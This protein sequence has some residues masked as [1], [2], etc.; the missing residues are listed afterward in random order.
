MTPAPAT[1]TAKRWKRPLFSFL[2][3]HWV[4]V[5]L[6]AVSMGYAG[7]VTLLHED[8]LSPVDEW[9]YVDYLYKLPAQG[10]VHE[11]EIV[12][13]ETLS[14]LACEGTSPFGT[15]GPPCAE[16]FGDTSKFPNEGV[17][18]AAAYT[19]LYFAS[20]RI[21]GD[22]IH[23]VTGIQQ[24]ESWRLTGVLWLAMSMVAF[25]ALARQWRVSNHAILSLGLAFIA[26]PLAW[27]TYT[28]VSTDAPSFFFGAAMLYLSEQYLRGKRSGWWLPIVS[29]LAVAVKLTNLLA[30]GLMAL[31][32]LV[33]WL[34]EIRQTSRIGLRSVQPGFTNRYSL[35]MLGFPV[36]AVVLSSTVQL[37][38][39]RLV[40]LMAVSDHRV[41]QGISGQLTG[42]ELLMQFTNFLPGAIVYSPISSFLPGF[43]FT[44]LTWICVASVL[45]AFFAMRARDD[46]SSIVI[47][48]TFAAA[49]FAPMLAIAL[50]T[51]TG[52]YFQLPSRY[53]APILAGFLLL[54][55]LLLRNK[56]ASWLVGLFATA[57]LVVGVWLSAYLATLT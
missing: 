15:I 14:L 38:W 52:S 44:P 1:P 48:V 42:S 45:G 13:D 5:A 47:A 39:M 33:R 4:A 7:T 55:G 8:A 27:W 34:R 40:P 46:S 49:F 24:L 25:Y 18:S 56:G 11:G 54:G 36:V 53:G 31:Y 29:V 26:S 51:M 2:K 23:A 43:V 35:S 16:E 9:V 21:V 6:V 32:L 19:P 10:M 20:T 37:I 17:T 50:Q 3:I 30:V 57:L 28:Y 22:A 12:G 41:D